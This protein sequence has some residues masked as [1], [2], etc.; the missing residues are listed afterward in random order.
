VN[1]GIHLAKQGKRL[2]SKL[3]VMRTALQSATY[4]RAAP[5]EAR[6]SCERTPA[7]SGAPGPFDAG[8]RQIFLGRRAMLPQLSGPTLRRAE[9][10]CRTVGARQYQSIPTTPSHESHM[11]EDSPMITPVNRSPSFADCVGHN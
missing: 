5:V 9:D 3:T 10:G 4:I 2:L 1:E 11:T 8:P 7:P 6:A